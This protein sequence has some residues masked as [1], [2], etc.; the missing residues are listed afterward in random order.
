MSQY[1]KVVRKLKSDGYQVDMSGADIRVTKGGQTE[2]FKTVEALV[3]KHGDGYNGLRYQ[4]VYQDETVDDSWEAK[5]RAF[6]K[7][8]DKFS[9]FTNPDKPKYTHVFH[10]FVFQDDFQWGRTS[11]PF[12]SYSKSKAAQEFMNEYIDKA[13]GRFWTPPPYG[14]NPY[15]TKK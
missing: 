6:E 10:E 12:D 15:N 9:K 11:N 13:T 8:A 3:E 2:S 5:K 7:A 14:K 4:K 1:A